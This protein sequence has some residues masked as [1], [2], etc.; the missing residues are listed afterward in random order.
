MPAD[1]IYVQITA[2]SESSAKSRTAIV[3]VPRACIDKF[4]QEKNDFRSEDN[5][6]AKSLAEPLAGYAFRHRTIFSTYKVAYSF[7]LTSP[8]EI[9]AKSPNLSQ[10]GLKAW[11]I[12]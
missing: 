9:E 7:S 8:L 6:V 12:S 1:D 10:A 4:R 3:R 2:S 5:I 11:V